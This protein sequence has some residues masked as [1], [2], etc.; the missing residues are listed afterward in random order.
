MI[1]CKELLKLC[2]RLER[3]LKLLY[4]EIVD[5]TSIRSCFF[6]RTGQRIEERSDHPIGL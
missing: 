3:P 4:L 1:A 5:L 6:E 2:F